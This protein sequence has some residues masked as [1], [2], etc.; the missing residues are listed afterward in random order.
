[1]PKA[2]APVGFYVATKIV[3]KL[4][5]VFGQISVDEKW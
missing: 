4:L 2:K 3:G 1:L 5:Y